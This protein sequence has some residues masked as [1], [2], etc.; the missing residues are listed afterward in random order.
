M[1]DLRS[2]A[3]LMS[4]QSGAPGAWQLGEQGPPLPDQPQPYPC[5]L[6][7]APAWQSPWAVQA[8]EVQAYAAAALLLY[9][10]IT[11]A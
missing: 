8:C 7:S 9:A 3:W 5:P 6:P 10:H 2:W 11:H 4:P 1:A